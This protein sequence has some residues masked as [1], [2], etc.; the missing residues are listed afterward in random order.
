MFWIIRKIRVVS[1]SPTS[2]APDNLKR[3][4]QLMHELVNCRQGK[5]ALTKY[6]QAFSN[7]I[8][9]MEDEK[10]APEFDRITDKASEWK[11]GCESRARRFFC[12]YLRS[13]ANYLEFAEWRLNLARLVETQGEK[14]RPPTVLE[15]YQR[16]EKRIEQ[17]E[18]IGESTWI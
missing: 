10:A 1:K 8:K 18:Q 13:N 9:A 3:T 4:L 7:I 17:K 5:M 2:S 6:Y 14:I 12:T 16:M 11:S 15:A